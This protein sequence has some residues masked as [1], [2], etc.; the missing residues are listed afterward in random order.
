MIEEKYIVIVKVWNE[1]TREVVQY[2]HGTPYKYGWTP[3]VNT[4]EEERTK[5]HRFI[6][7][8]SEN[9]PVIVKIDNIISI[10]LVESE[11]YNKKLEE[12]KRI[13]MW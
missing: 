6:K 1:Y 4:L 10:H 7:I 9:G 13:Q 8:T 12:S 11:P 3:D 5:N 2:K